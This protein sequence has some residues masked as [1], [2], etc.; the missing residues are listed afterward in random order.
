MAVRQLPDSGERVETGAVQFGD[1]WP[2][3]FI[4]GDHALYYALCLNLQRSG[5]AGPIEDSNVRGLA[6]IL[7]S[8][9][10]R[11]QAVA[12]AEQ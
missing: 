10:A 4:R 6:E 11:K 1:D 12:K 8:C 7:G 5:A 3:V 2:G 9:D